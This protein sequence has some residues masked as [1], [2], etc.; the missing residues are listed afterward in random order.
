MKIIIK[1]N[2]Q[3]HQVQQTNKTYQYDVDNRMSKAMYTKD[4]VTTLN[5]QNLYNGNNCY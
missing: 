4:G 1:Q 3:I 5:Q 2:I